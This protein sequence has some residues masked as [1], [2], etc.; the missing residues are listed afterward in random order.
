MRIL[1]VSGADEAYYPLLDDLVCSLRQ[2]PR[3][4]F[5]DIGCLDVGLS[6]ASR[7][8]LAGRVTRIVEPGWDLPLDAELREARPGLRAL[9]ARAFLPAYFPDYDIYVWIDADAWVQQPFAIEWYIEAAK[10]GQVGAVSHTHAAYQTTEEVLRWRM[11]RML[12]YFGQEYAEGVRGD[13]YLNSGAWAARG[14]S[15]FWAAWARSFKKGLQACDGKIC[16]DQAALNHA[17]WTESLP[18]RLLPATCNWL[19]HL[20]LPGLDSGGHGFCEPIQ[21]AHIIGI[22]HLTSKA[23]RVHEYDLRGQGASGT[24][25]LRFPRTAA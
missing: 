4:G 18:V 8:S 16:T 17:V 24:M 21:P 1:I 9:T 25:S 3:L 10:A 13:A 22:M 23:A 6:A 19:T 5:L 2:W 11:D 7:A 14:D 12:A 15:P 20:S